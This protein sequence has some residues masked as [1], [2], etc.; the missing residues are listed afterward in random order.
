MSELPVQIVNLRGVILSL[1]L[2]HNDVVV[3]VWLVLMFCTSMAFS[4]VFATYYS[5]HSMNLFIAGSYLS[6]VK[7]INRKDSEDI[8]DFIGN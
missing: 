4:F 1:S 3:F 6:A 7:Q 2:A 8:L 5:D